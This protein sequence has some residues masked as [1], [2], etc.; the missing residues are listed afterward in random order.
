MVFLGKG[1]ITMAM[2]KK[3]LCSDQ[4]EQQRVNALSALQI[5]DTHSEE[6]YDRLVRLA[7]NLLKSPIC[8]IAFL[9]E[10]RLWF[11]SL[12]GLKENETPREIAFCN[13]TIKRNEPLIIQD[14]T[15]DHRFVNNPFVRNSPFIRFYAGVPLTSPDGYNVGTFGLADTIP[16]DLKPEQLELLI[17]LAN[18]AKDELSLRY[19]NHVLHKI[20]KQL[21]IRNDLLR[22][23]FSFY[24][25]DEVVNTILASP[26]PH[27]L[28]GVKL[29][30]PFYL[31]I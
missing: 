23:T 18:I 22:K 7:V 19:S 14:L 26:A 8:Y 2:A 20:R 15:L 3:A 17:N 21:E 16:K 13:E 10:K 1:V 11:K 27:K 25:S 28:G 30:L 24:M 4:L 29:K 5:M 6:G 12:H 31:V 9:D